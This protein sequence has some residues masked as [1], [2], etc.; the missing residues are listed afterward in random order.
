MDRIREQQRALIAYLI[1][2]N[3]VNPVYFFSASTKSAENVSHLVYQPFVF[4]V[5][6]FDFRELFK[7]AALLARQRGRR[8]DR[9]RDEEVAAT[10]TAKHRHAVS[11]QAKDRPGLRP[12]G[13]FHL[14]LAA[15]SLHG[16]LRAECSLCES[17]RDC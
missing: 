4:K 3:L 2:V 11:F 6:G 10:A 8:H 16:K 7:D 1:P 15:K 12:G 5:C 14:L 13:N 17:N 9:D